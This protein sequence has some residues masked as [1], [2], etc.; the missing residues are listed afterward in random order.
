MLISVLVVNVLWQ[1]TGQ[2][3]WQ[4]LIHPHQDYVLTDL[5]PTTLNPVCILPQ[6]HYRS[7]DCP[8]FRV[9]GKFPSKKCEF[10]GL[11]VPILEN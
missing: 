7:W 3:Q 5:M 11:K 4:F 9:V 6:W 2:L 1:V 8:L 10:W